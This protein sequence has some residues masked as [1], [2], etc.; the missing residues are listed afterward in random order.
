[1]SAI[2]PTTRA[3]VKEVETDVN[4]HFTASVA[5]GTYEVQSSK[6]GTVDNTKT[7]TV[8]AGETATTTIMNAWVQDQEAARLEKVAQ[9]RLNFGSKVDRGGFEPP[10]TSPISVLP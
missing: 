9:R 5:P 3:V 1:M 7:V 2:D 4:G 6:E 10:F 8:E